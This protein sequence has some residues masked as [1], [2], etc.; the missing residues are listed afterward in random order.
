VK[1]RVS[2]A[3]LLGVAALCAALAGGA[4]LALGRDGRAAPP[5]FLTEPAGRGPLSARVTATGVVEPLATVQVGTYVSGPVR[6]LY[7]DFNSRVK[8]GQLVARIDPAPF[9]VR[10]RQAEANLATARAEADKARADL[11]RKQASLGRSRALRE[12]GFLSEEGL[13]L[14]VSEDAQARAQL[15][16]EEAGVAQAEAALAEARIQLGYTDIVSPVDGVVISRSVDV[17][18]TVAASFQTPTLFEIAEDLAQMRVR[19]N[20]SES[21]IGGVAEGQRAS[22]AVDAWPGRRFEGRVVQVRSAPVTLQ[23]VVTYDAVI[24]VANPDLALRPGMTAS[25]EITT[26]ER[27]DALRVPLRALRFR[28]EPE[29]GAARAQPESDAPAVY[30]LDAGGGLRRVELRTGV[31]DERFAEVLGGELSPGDPVVVAYARSE[32]PAPPGASSSP[33]L[34]RRPR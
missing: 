13:E 9:E 3:R 16:L 30:V 32:E 33:F 4:W 29:A 15:A 26:A 31:R 10:V 34:P 11:D 23:N 27:G 7:A 6:A 17:G 24:E 19:A 1:G 2:G 22:F 18:Q 25:V 14:A 8:R 28:P 5:A 12:R 21:D 20:V